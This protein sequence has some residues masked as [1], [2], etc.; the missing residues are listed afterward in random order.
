MD[1]LKTKKV[2]PIARLTFSG[3]THIGLI[4]EANEDCFC[5]LDYHDE[6]NSMAV[7]ADGIGGH[8]NGEVASSLCCRQFVASWKFHNIGNLNSPARIKAYLRHQIR[9]VNKEIFI[10]NKRKNFACPMGT[11]AVVAVFTPECVIVGHA[12]DSRLYVFNGEQLKQLTDDHSLVATLVKRGTITSEEAKTHPFSHIISKSIGPNPSVEPKLSIYER[13]PDGR[14]LLC[15][16]GLSMHVSNKRIEE[17]LGGSK[18]AKIA[19]NALMKEA[20]I[21]GGEDNI[22]IICAF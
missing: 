14:Y 17:I 12:G 13:P 19:V 15:S 8:Q 7:I 4:R 22:S 6:I 16:D 18:T 9:A 20:L 2:H 1:R 5:Y 11:T 21:S 3:E 10:Q